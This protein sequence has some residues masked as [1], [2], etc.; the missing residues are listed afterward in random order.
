MKKVEKCDYCKRELPD[1]VSVPRTYASTIER[2]YKIAA[3]KYNSA[4][5]INGKKRWHRKM[6]YLILENDFD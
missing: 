6:D 3:E 1:K 4:R 5:T 2:D